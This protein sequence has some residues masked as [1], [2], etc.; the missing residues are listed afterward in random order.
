MRVPVLTV[1][2]G[3]RSLWM[4]T[5]FNLLG[6]G[7]GVICWP[8]SQRID[9]LHARARELYAEADANE[10]EARLTSGLRRSEARAYGDV[11]RLAG[12]SSAGASMAAVLL[13]LNREASRFSVEIRSITP[14]VGG[15]QTPGGPSKPDPLAEFDVELSVHGSFKDI[16]AFLSDV[17][18][19]EV[20]VAPRSASL[21][22][23]GPASLRPMLNASVATTIYFLKDLTKAE[24]RHATSSVRS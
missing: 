11:I 5:A 23:D 22:L 13:L 3:V 21:S 20:L 4:L 7:M 6:I 2:G 8:A 1:R 18:R 15:S 12:Q 9:A 24:T 19:H 14:P 16:V 17:S 10:R